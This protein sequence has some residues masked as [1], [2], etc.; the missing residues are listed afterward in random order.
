M[1]VAIRNIRVLGDL[2]AALLLLFVSGHLKMAA[3][4]TIWYS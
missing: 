2:I 3:A 1:Q 4:A